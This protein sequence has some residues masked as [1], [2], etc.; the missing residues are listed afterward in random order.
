MK[1]WHWAIGCSLVGCAVLVADA[2]S[3]ASAL[4]KVN[5]ILGQL[6]STL[7]VFGG[8][9][10]ANAIKIWHQSQRAASWPTVS[11]IITRSRVESKK[12]RQGGTMY[13]TTGRSTHYRPDLAYTYQVE[14]V[15]FEGRRA[16]FGTPSRWS[17]DRA[18]YEKIIAPYSTGQ[19]VQVRYD[20]RHPGESVLEL[21]VAPFWRSIVCFAA[22]CLALGIFGLV[23]G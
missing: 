22:V 9:A 10:G 8:L 16:R 12:M 3:V 11:G 21:Q 2:G 7:L 6:A 17:K 23:H 14:G 13:R 5:E 19:A 20:P 1:F 18:R 15:H 4:V